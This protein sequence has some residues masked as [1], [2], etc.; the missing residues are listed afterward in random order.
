MGT[1]INVELSIN[2]IRN[3]RTWRGLNF[4][5]LFSVIRICLA[6]FRVFLP[7]WVKAEKPMKISDHLM[8]HL[9]LLC[10]FYSFQCVFFC[11]LGYGALSFFLHFCTFLRNFCRSLLILETPSNAILI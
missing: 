2:G 6:L 10:T 3:F 4:F 7:T 1:E 11:M 8:P 9:R 5:C